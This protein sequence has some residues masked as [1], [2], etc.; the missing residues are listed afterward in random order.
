MTLVIKWKQEESYTLGSYKILMRLLTGIVHHCGGSLQWNL[1]LGEISYASQGCKSALKLY[2]GEKPYAP[3]GS[4][5]CISRK[6]I[7]LSYIPT[8]ILVDPEGPINSQGPKVPEWRGQRHETLAAAQPHCS[9]PA[10]WAWARWRWPWREGFVSAGV[11]LH[12][13]WKWR[14]RRR[15]RRQML[16]KLQLYVAGSCFLQLG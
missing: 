4:G 12:A 14:R 5:I 11:G 13:Q 10:E 2:A 8:L 15:P 16:W 6:L 3:E 9:E 7:Q 1:T